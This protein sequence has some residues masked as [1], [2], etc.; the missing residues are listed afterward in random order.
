VYAQRFTRTGA[1]AGPEFRAN[2]YTQNQQ[3]NPT[4]AT[5]AA[6]DFVIAWESLGQDPGGSTGIFAQRYAAGGATAGGELHVNNYT[7]SDQNL[8]AAA[9]DADGD[10]VIT[11]QGYE[12]GGNYGVFARRFDAGTGASGAEF[13]VST[14]VPRFQRYAAI[15]MDADGDFVVTWQNEFGD[16]N[17]GET[18]V[19][20]QRFAASGARVGVEFRVNTTTLGNHRYPAAAMDADGDFVIAWAGYGQDPGDNA[21]ASGVYA[22]RYAA[23]RPLAVAQVYASG[24]TWGPAFRNAAGSGPFGYPIGGGAT[25]LAVLPWGSVNQISIAF[26]DDA[27]ADAGDLEVRG[28]NVADYPVTGYAYNAAARTGTWTLGRSIEA[29]KIYIDLDG[30]ARV[31]VRGGPG[32]APLDGEWATGRGYP[33]GDGAPGGDF[34]FR[35]HVLPGDGTRDGVVNASDFAEIKRR[36]NRAPGDGVT[37]ATA[38][39]PFAD[40]TADARINA[41]DLA[42]MKRRANSRLP[43]TEPTA[44]GAAPLAWAAADDSLRPAVRVAE[45]LFESPGVLD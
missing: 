26:S 24:S 19:D 35:V 32:N 27:Q 21:N 15:A 43:A 30:G 42:D 8:P 7:V 33:S 9:M 18:S 31:G 16:A 2:S 40:T 14:T 10:F 34:L 38:Y 36:L 44:L 22:Q 6:G 45:A 39:S 13:K 29:D 12:Q 3:W 37:G 17:L 11:W 41:L 20:A 5:D 4:V 1:A 25:Q 23:P 28:V